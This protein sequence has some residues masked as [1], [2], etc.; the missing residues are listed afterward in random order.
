MSPVAARSVFRTPLALLWL[1]GVMLFGCVFATPS[2]S[3]AQ[4]PAATAKRVDTTVDRT[5][6][7][8]TVE[9]YLRLARAGEFELAAQCLDLKALTAANRKT[10]GPTLARDLLTVLDRKLLIDLAKLS[11]EPE[12]DKSDKSETELLGNIPL[13]GE[14]IPVSLS[15]SREGTVYFWQF[16]AVTVSALPGLI[17]RYGDQWIEPLLP[18]SLVATKFFNVA[19]WQWLGLVLVVALSLLSGKILGR[20][21][22]GVLERL[23]KRTR[24]SWDDALALAARKPLRPVAAVVTAI[25]LLQ[26]LRLPVRVSTVTDHLTRTLLIIFIA[27]LAMRMIDVGA[28]VF[29]GRLPEDTVGELETRGLRTQL[30]LARR[31]A[32]ILVV[33]LAAAA[34]LMQF[35]VVR[36][37]GVS[38]LA[39]AGIL[40]VVL[41]LAA[42]K[43]I[44]GVF[45]GIQLSISQPVRIGD[46]V[47]VENEMGTIEEINLTYLVVKLWDERRL[48]VPI[49]RFLEAPFQNWSKMGAPLLG[50]IFV[51]ADA[52]T[53]VAL[54]RAELE[55][56]VS[57]HRCWD[58]RI[59]T[60]VLSETTG[61][62]VILRALVS[63]PNPDAMFD[64][65][66][67]VREALV[68]FLQQY[69]GG[70][71]LPRRRI[72]QVSA[73]R[74]DE[75]PRALPSVRVDG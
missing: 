1:L 55:R 30:Q 60:L 38:L 2:T 52:S 28:E 24:V 71:Y 18:P 58:G 39:S 35:E 26:L 70:I 31:L 13:D 40:S 34:I 56:F 5:T 23:A 44:A 69:E 8:K 48:V 17:E 12:G 63:A 21:I 66:H 33:V 64:L 14:A 20:F 22:G 49:T 57:Q 16:S 68:T 61:D 74:E 72:A 29:E 25:A 43:S 27:R 3:L 75:P 6:P 51:H 9:T 11:D 50:T 41:G 19:A 37:V 47:V 32:A 73:G 7:R 59:C 42:Q 15:R 46:F 67:A 53:P 10:D 62:S 36:N 45:A 4:T 65:R 54:V